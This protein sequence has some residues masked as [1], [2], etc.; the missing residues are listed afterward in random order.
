VADIGSD[1]SLSSKYDYFPAN[2]IQM[3]VRIYNQSRSRL[4]DIGDFNVSARG[5][6]GGRE[7]QLLIQPDVSINSVYQSVNAHTF[8]TATDYYN[9]LACDGSY[10]YIFFV[11][12]ARPFQLEVWVTLFATLLVLSLVFI[13]HKDISS[14]NLEYFITSK[15]MATRDGQALNKI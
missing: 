12:F 7:N 5:R 4:N 15:V 1:T 2:I 8:L 11:A 6:L 3:G 13:Q 14:F 9:L 10:T